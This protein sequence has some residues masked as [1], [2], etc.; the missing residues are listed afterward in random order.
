MRFVK[1]HG[2]GNDFIV[3]VDGTPTPALAS[4]L[5]RRGFSIGADGVMAVSPPS[6]G[7]EAH[8]HV[9]MDLINSDGSLPEMCGNGIRCLVKDAVDRL[10]YRQNPLLV[11]TPAGVLACEWVAEERG[12]A[13]VRV[14]MSR[15]TFELE[16]VPADPL[17]GRLSG[18][19]LEL[20]LDSRPVI[21]LPVNTGNPHFVVFGDASRER[22]LAD[23]PRLE[24]HPAF[25]KKANIEFAEALS[26]THLKVTVWER[27]CGLT[28]ACGTGATATT[29]AAIRAGLAAADTPVRVT[30]PGGDLLITVSAD[31]SSAHMDGP[32]E[33][34]FEGEVDPAFPPWPPA[35]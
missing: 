10:G 12:V 13:R 15:P 27:G 35:R 23:G 5:C 4:H 6:P 1:Y 3:L 9:R 14:A 22:A 30:L 7:A 8:A 24:N 19:W 20:D 34:A 11:E 25:P 32:V 33:K 2:L 31:F 21:G 17:A 18:P 16:A 26:P 29:A 28:L